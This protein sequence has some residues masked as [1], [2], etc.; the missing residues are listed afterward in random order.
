MAES[1]N[2]GVK[3]AREWCQANNIPLP[4]P[5]PVGPVPLPPARTSL[6]FTEQMKG[7][8]AA[9]ETDPEA[10]RRKGKAEGTRLDVKLTI[11]ID[12]ADAFITDPSHPARIEGTIDSV[13]VGGARPV[14]RGTFNLL[15]HTSDPRKK[16]M[17]YRFVCSDAGGH[18]VTL[19]GVKHVENDEGADAWQD[20]TTLY[21]KLFEG[22][23]EEQ[24]EAGASV[25]GAGIIQIHPLDFLQQLTTF[26]TE[27][28]TL[29]ARIGALNRFGALFLGKLWDVYGRPVANATPE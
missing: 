2:L 9:G 25:R 14:E 1:A 15:V 19:S 26:R 3:I 21:V 5:G 18:Q 10:G 17:L 27:G 13:L 4:N 16:Q 7:Y 22:V 6:R 24:Q 29:S 8:A 28:P 12:D 23:V 20:T 11:L